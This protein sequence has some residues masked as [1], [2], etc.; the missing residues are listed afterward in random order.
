MI[1]PRCETEYRE[2]FTVCA[3]CGVELLAELPARSPKP[4]PGGDFAKLF[5]VMDWSQYDILRAHLEAAG[6][7]YLP[8]I[9][10]A[11]RLEPPFVL[12]V[13]ADRLPEAEALLDDLELAPEPSGTADETAKAEDSA[14]PEEETEEEEEPAEAEPFVGIAVEA[15]VLRDGRYLVV[16]EDGR[17]TLPGGVVVPDDCGEGSIEAVLTRILADEYQ[18]AIDGHPAYVTSWFAADYL[19]L[20]FLARWRTERYLAEGEE[21]YTAGEAAALEDLASERRTGLERADRIRLG[22]NW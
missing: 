21:W 5:T 2:G 19:H 22:L 7:R 16:E 17:R 6:I 3:D 11:E 8:P 14:A 10:L 20:L 13:E 15:A 9:T 18:I 12:V 1:C 4:A